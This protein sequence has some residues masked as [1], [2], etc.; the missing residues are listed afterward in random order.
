MFGDLIFSSYL[1]KVKI[2]N[3]KKG[4]QANSLEYKLMQGSQPHWWQ[5]V[6]LQLLDKY[7]RS[8]ASS[9]ADTGK[10]IF[11]LLQG[12]NQMSDKPG[13]RH[14]RSKKAFW[15]FNEVIK[16]I[17]T[18]K[19]FSKFFKSFITINYSWILLLF[20]NWGHLF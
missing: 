14:P 18:Q 9:I 19:F 11:S 8:P 6:I 2:E 16:R 5:A 1:E 17:S 4:V 10:T 7:G 12:V 20:L 15:F 13:S 3:N